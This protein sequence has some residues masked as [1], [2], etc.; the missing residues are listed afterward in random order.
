VTTLDDLAD[1]LPWGFHDAHLEALTIDWLGQTLSLVARFPMSK[2]QD[3]ERR[4]RVVVSGLFFCSIDPAVSDG[5]GYET[6]PKGGL[7]IDAREGP[8]VGASGLPTLPPG[9]FLQHIY[10]LSW[11]CRAIH[12]AGRDCRLEWLGEESPRL[13]SGGALYAGDEIPDP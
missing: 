8:A 9:V 11:N 5:D 13:T 6:I 7:W 2:R 12:I 4:G 3:I 10:V 1:Q